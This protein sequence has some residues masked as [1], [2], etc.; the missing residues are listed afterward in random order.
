MGLSEYT[1]HSAGYYF[2]SSNGAVT[3]A[4]C[5]HTSSSLA[6]YAWN[7]FEGV[8]KV[9]FAGHLAVRITFLEAGSAFACSS[10]EWQ[11]ESVASNKHSHVGH[12]PQQR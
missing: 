5:F 10:L 1:S 6:A 4:C 7:I 8:A 3:A 11:D 9:G 12:I 2:F